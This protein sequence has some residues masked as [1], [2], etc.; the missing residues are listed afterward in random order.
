MEFMLVETEDAAAREHVLKPLDDYNEAM[1]GRGTSEPVRPISILRREGDLVGGLVGVSYWDWLHVDLFYLPPAW[2]GAGLGARIMA[3]LVGAAAGRGLTGVWLGSYSFQAPGFYLRQG[4]AEFAVLPDHPP[5]FR[6]HIFL[7][8][9][10]GNEPAAQAPEGFVLRD[11][12]PPAERALISQGLRAYNDAAAGTGRFQ[13]LGLLLPGGGGLWGETGRGWLFVELLG[14]P[15]AARGDGIG[16]RL[17]REAERIAAA[18]GC[19]GVHLD[20]C[21]F[22][23]PGFYEK[24][25]YTRLGT[26]PEQPRG[27]TRHLYARRLDG[28]PLLAHNAPP[29]RDDGANA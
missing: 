18:R 4:F 14:I 9:L 20:T 7:R 12:I 5:G 2:R 29:P 26:V 15:E 25:G 23:A 13:P 3:T 21:S 6:E 16:T 19:V 11:E 8:R 28:R 24:L 27:F 1:I 22:Q 10:G 17:M